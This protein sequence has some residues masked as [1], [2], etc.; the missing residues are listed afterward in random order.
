[1]ITAKQP[2]YYIDADSIDIRYAAYAGPDRFTA[3]LRDDAAV[4]VYVPEVPR[5]G[6]RSDGSYLSFHLQGG[7]NRLIKNRNQRKCYIYVCFPK[8]FQ[9]F[10]DTAYLAF[11][12]TRIPISVETADFTPTPEALALMQ[13]NYYIQIGTI[14]ADDN[15]ELDTGALGTIAQQNAWQEKLNEVPTRI[16]V[17]Y[18]LADHTILPNGETPHMDWGTSLK[19][20]ARLLQEWATDVTKQVDHWLIVRDSGDAVA[21]AAWNATATFTGSIDLSFNQ[22]RNDIGTTGEETK[23]TL[24][25]YTA[26]D[27]AIATRT[28]VITHTD[29]QTWIVEYDAPIGAIN[30]DP[31]GNV[32][33]GLWR[34]ETSG[35]VTYREYLLHSAISVRRG[36]TLLTIAPN[37]EAPGPGQYQIY[38]QAAD[39][40]LMVQNSTVYIV[41]IKN[42]KDG[43]AGS[44]DDKWEDADY[45][46]MRKMKDAEAVFVVNCEGLGAITKRFSIVVNHDATP[47]VAVDMAPTTAE[48][49]FDEQYRNGSYKAE[50]SSFG[51]LPVDVSLIARY[52]EE[53]VRITGCVPYLDGDE[54]AEGSYKLSHYNSQDPDDP[55]NG[56]IESISILSLPKPGK[57]GTLLN[58][59]I[60]SIS[61]TA[62]YAGVSYERVMRLPLTERYKAVTSSNVRHFLLTA[63]D[64]WGTA[65]VPPYDYSGWTTTPATTEVSEQYPYL[66]IYDETIFSNGKTSNEKPIL[67]G[68]WAESA[69]TYFMTV[70][71]STVPTGADG[72]IKA[73]AQN[74]VIVPYK[75]LGTGATQRIQEAG[76]KLVVTAYDNAGQAVGTD[77]SSST[78]TSQFSKTWTPVAGAVRAIVKFTDANN[79]ELC[80]SV[81][82][83]YV[84]DGEK[85]DDAVVYYLDIDPS[86]LALAP[87]GDTFTD[88]TAR[89]NLSVVVYRRNGT[90]SPT[91]AGANET[92]THITISY[93]DGRQPDTD[94]SYSNAF[95]VAVDTAMA[96]V[97]MVLKE[98][99]G[100]VA[101]DTRTITIQ[102][103][104]LRGYQ[105]P[106]PRR[107]QWQ[108]NMVWHAGA[109][110]DT[111]KD[112]CVIKDAAGVVHQYEC[113]ASF[114]GAS[115]DPP[116]SDC[117]LLPDGSA[118]SHANDYWRT[119][120]E[121]FDFV[122]T[123][124][125]LSQEV[126]ADSGAFDGLRVNFLTV[127][128][129][130]YIG[131]FMFNTPYTLLPA[132][133]KQCV[134]PYNYGMTDF[135]LWPSGTPD[136]D[137]QEAA[138][139][140]SLNVMFPD[141]GS[142]IIIT[143]ASLTG[144]NTAAGVPTHYIYVN[145]PFAVPFNAYYDG[146]NVRSLSAA[147]V[148]S[149]L[150]EASGSAFLPYIN[151]ES[152]LYNQHTKAL[153]DQMEASEAL[154][155]KYLGARMTVCNKIAGNG[156]VIIYGVRDIEDYSDAN[157]PTNNEYKEIDPWGRT[158]FFWGMSSNSN[159]PYVSL[160]SAKN[161]IDA[162]RYMEDPNESNQPYEH[163][164]PTK[165]YPV[166]TAPCDAIISGHGTA[167]KLQ[168]YLET[169]TQSRATRWAQVAEENKENAGAY[170]YLDP[171]EHDEGEQAPLTAFWLQKGWFVTLEM[172]YEEGY[173][174]WKIINHGP[175]PTTPTVG[176]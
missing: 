163:M 107:R 142:S 105:G 120:T 21:D 166:G 77:T 23:F 76:F 89:K 97:T 170:K 28:V 64:D 140:E 125:L 56:S 158:S 129:N 26:D 37:N 1:M 135:I 67:M 17:T 171:L 100:S 82:I 112:F 65:G 115:L 152:D 52:N 4:L 141:C 151:E 3:N 63:N 31:Q 101:L 169:F 144:Y 91:Q 131:G 143:D 24:T 132:D 145:L 43:V 137:V 162:Y 10:G 92:E 86:A 9:E 106:S 173:Y 36:N 19:M 79:N 153:F 155:H 154:C 38:P 50:N 109:A 87:G 84:A 168:S 39:C 78:T 62:T 128:R 14:Y 104:G 172:T 108:P 81:T 5:L 55:L 167:I 157:D 147:Q 74:I 138:I 41:A 80:T 123:N 44:D 93:R 6:Y 121:Q 34:E 114:N 35:G 75:R 149:A 73:P 60:I 51:G 150:K 72:T 59:R 90:S 95:T 58:H 164:D 46:L 136:I 134:N 174:F 116:N 161:T 176:S 113:K 99:D 68:N 94:R 11:N 53:R 40:T 61:M 175:I 2:H 25:A 85:G 148:A 18:E 139:Y 57:G 42:I 66:W 22:S 102:S 30:V 119:P 32:K 165:T 111:W 133:I 16:E 118:G 45:E 20:N 110:G 7:G 13:E 71:P 160:K 49:T 27:T 48:V 8:N 70:E 146:N 69:I 159:L 126:L 15:I 124:V 96:A 130:S 33:G 47:Y 127:D 88:G 12:P 117:P 103:A 98:R 156:E 54:M 83:P 29:L 122:T